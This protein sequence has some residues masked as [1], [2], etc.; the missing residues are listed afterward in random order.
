MR[1]N[2]GLTLIRVHWLAISPLASSTRPNG[3]SYD[4]QYL[5]VGIADVDTLYVVD[6]DDG[7]VVRTVPLEQWTADHAVAG[8][9]VWIMEGHVGY[10]FK[11]I[12]P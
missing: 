2:W 10:R 4:G 5:W 6:K 12:V 1:L 7:A 9:H 8:P 3:L 11:R